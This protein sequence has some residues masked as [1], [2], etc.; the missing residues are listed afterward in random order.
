M[1]ETWDGCTLL[2]S[3]NRPD[4]VYRV[5]VNISMGRRI[6]WPTS[7]DSLD[8]Y[9]DLVTP[10]EAARLYGCTRENI[11]DLKSRG[12]LPV[13]QYKGQLL[14]RANDVLLLRDFITSRG[15]PRGG[16][17]NME[18]SSMNNRNI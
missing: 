12:Q 8:E 4:P 11:Y 7:L 6:I 14:H 5:E 10:T 2:P 15:I 18:V 9:P 16:K 13:Y 17:R 3:S 1:A